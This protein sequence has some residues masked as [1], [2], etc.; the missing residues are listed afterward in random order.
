MTAQQHTLDHGGRHFG[1]RLIF[2]IIFIS[3]GSAAFGFSNSVI[4][5]TLGQPSFLSKMGLDTSKHADALISAILAVYYAGG[6]FGSLCHGILA[7]RYGRKMS[8]TVSC[9]IMII[10]SAICTGSSNIAVYITFRFFCGWSSYQFLCTIPTWVTEITP[11]SHRGILGNIIAVNIGVGYVV[12]AFSSVGFYFVSGDSQWRGPTGL[13][14]FFPGLLLSV[15]YWLPESPRYLIAQ[16]R[17]QEALSNLQSLHSRSGHESH[18]FAEIEFYQIQKQIEFDTARKMS[19]VQIFKHPSMRKR[20]LITICLTWCMVGSG[21][22]VINNYG[23]AI[24]GSLGYGPLDTLFF[25]AGWVSI[26]MIAPFVSMTFVDRVSRTYMFATG[27]FLCMCTLI[28]EA[29]LQKNFLGSENKAGLAGAVA[30]IYL[31]VFFYV[32][33]LDGPMFFYIGE[34]WPSQVRAQGFSLGIGA[35]CLSNLVWTAAAPQAFNSIGW[36]YYILFIVQAAFGGVATILWFPNTLGKPLEEIAVL[37]GDEA[38]VVVFQSELNEAQV[39]NE[40]D[41]KKPGGHE[42]VE[43]VERSRV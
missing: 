27:F 36:K 7:D 42:E 19:Y 30:M 11:P 14:M 22:L 32:V 10:A 37:F 15:M 34:I 3:F 31:Y 6:V 16:G 5:S 29:A 40:I 38:D 1:G 21:V 18:H 12:A 9:I 26:V 33:F 39:I 8:A 2:V 17:Q 25:L 28:A 41:L 4:G 35:M 24:Y 13:Q 20:A 23:A 43:N